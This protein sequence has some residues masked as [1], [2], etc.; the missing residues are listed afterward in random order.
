[1]DTLHSMKKIFISINLSFNND[2]MPS[3]IENKNNPDTLITTYFYFTGTIF[4]RKR[5]QNLFARK[6]YNM[7]G[8][9]CLSCNL[10]YVVFMDGNTV[11]KYFI[12]II[13]YLLNKYKSKFNR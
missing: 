9:P 13:I 2:Y 11:I 12:L 8:Q 10:R 6:S 7:V 1:M 4:F 3:D 5:S